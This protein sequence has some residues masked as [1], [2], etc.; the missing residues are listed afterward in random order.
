[1][2]T[3]DIDVWQ[4]TSPFAILFFLGRIIRL[5]T[6]NAWQSL[7]PLLAFLVAYQGDLVSKL[8]LGGIVFGTS[9]GFGASRPT[10]SRQSGR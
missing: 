7:A 2:K 10:L 4:R 3:P 6:K 5:I 1:M 8:M 9:A